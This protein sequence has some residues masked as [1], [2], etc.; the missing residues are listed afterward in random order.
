L[1]VTGDLHITDH[2][3]WSAHR[4]TLICG[5]PASG[6]STLARTLHPNVLELEDIEAETI[7]ELGSS[8]LLCVVQFQ[9][10]YWVFSSIRVGF[11]RPYSHRHSFKL[12]VIHSP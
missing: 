10:P 11:R 5:P 9:C 1:T 4:V 6:K 3:Q 8:L 12:S 7:F 2:P